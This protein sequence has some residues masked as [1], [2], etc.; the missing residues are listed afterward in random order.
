MK[1]WIKNDCQS[2]RLS[3]SAWLSWEEGSNISRFPPFQV[4]PCSAGSPGASG[5]GD[6][7]SGKLSLGLFGDCP[8]RIR[9]DMGRFSTL[10][11]G[12][13][14][15]R[16]NLLMKIVPFSSVHIELPI[17]FS[18][19]PHFFFLIQS[20]GISYLLQCKFRARLAKQWH[21]DLCEL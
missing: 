21:W 3:L 11:K 13:S 15:M 19:E 4:P 16:D 14:S 6:G 1:Q 7:C 18:K 9:A 20:F 5:M 2:S 10:S 17:I 8:H 12:K